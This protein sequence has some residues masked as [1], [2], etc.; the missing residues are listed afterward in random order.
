[1]TRAVFTPSHTNLLRLGRGG[2]RVD[3]RVKTCMYMSA[4][5]RSKL[6]FL[7]AVNNYRCR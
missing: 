3:G 2:S 1:M 5:V 4:F 7:S 6:H